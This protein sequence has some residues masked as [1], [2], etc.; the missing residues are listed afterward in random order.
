[1]LDTQR[2][3]TLAGRKCFARRRLCRTS[4][5]GAMCCSLWHR[6][7]CFV[8]HDLQKEGRRML[9]LWKASLPPWQCPWRHVLYVSGKVQCPLITRGS[10]WA[11]GK[12]W[13]GC[14]P[15]QIFMATLSLDLCLGIST[16][17]GVKLF[18]YHASNFELSSY[19]LPALHCKW[20]PSIFHFRL[21]VI[22]EVLASWNTLAPVLLPKIDD[23]SLSLERI[24]QTA[25]LIELH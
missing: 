5:Q 8:E 9:D 14:S 11:I 21:M 22:C 19:P 17:A 3:Q 1:M 12:V 20:K 25:L 23:R 18:F 6:R 15:K 4:Q 2:C 16:V 7:S 13:Y 10:T 24:W